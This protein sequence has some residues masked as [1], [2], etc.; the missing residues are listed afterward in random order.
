M[1]S[2]TKCLCQQAGQLVDKHFI[3]GLARE[4][5]DYLQSSE[6]VV[7]QDSKQEMQSSADKREIPFKHKKKAF[8]GRVVAHCS[9]CPESL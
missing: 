8:T 2:W 9:S 1:L 3:Q 6:E 7:E 5:D 4:R